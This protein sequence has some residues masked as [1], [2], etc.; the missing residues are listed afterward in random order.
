MTD[1]GA[2]VAFDLTINLG[3]A[4]EIA[5][6]AFG[7]VGG[8]YHLKYNVSQ[9]GDRENQRHKENLDRHRENLERFQELRTELAKQTDIL[10]ELARQEG[11]IGE[12]KN[13]LQN[14]ER[15]IR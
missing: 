5:T 11:I 3:Q 7:I 12:L 4:I 14:L 6:F 8:W 13:R 1:T 15:N 9:I 2:N 10:V